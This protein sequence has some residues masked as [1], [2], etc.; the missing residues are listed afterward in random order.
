M[1]GNSR[2]SWDRLV[3][4][5]PENYPTRIVIVARLHLHICDG[6]PGLFVTLEVAL[7]CSLTYEESLPA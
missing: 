7:G 4:N 1:N 3:V 5:V 6:A 2:S